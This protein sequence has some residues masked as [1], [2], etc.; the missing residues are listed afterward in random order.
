MSLR[1][2]KAGL[3]CG[4]M[5]ALAASISAAELKASSDE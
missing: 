1:D 4:H 3:F 2:Q 5:D